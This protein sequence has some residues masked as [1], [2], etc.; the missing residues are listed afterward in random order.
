MTTTSKLRYQVMTIDMTADDRTPINLDGSDDD[1]WSYQSRDL[2]SALEL[3][4]S[5]VLAL[6]AGSSPET[7]AV[8]RAVNGPDHSEPRTAYRVTITAA[9]GT[10]T[11]DEVV[12]LR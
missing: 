12:Y 4:A 3:R 8:V 5:Y 7:G 9:N 10:V 6:V 11:T 2:F 1:G